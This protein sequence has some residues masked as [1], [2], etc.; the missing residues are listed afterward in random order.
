M[1]WVCPYHHHRIDGWYLE[2]R[3]GRVWCTAPPWL[4]PT[5]TPRLNTYFYPPDLLNEDD[6]RAASTGPT[7]PPGRTDQN[8]PSP[9]RPDHPKINTDTDADPPNLFT[10]HH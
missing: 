2:R 4:D 3:G 7:R 5:Q 8:K 6:H 1:G 10:P 9:N